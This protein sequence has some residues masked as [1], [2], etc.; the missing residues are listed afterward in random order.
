MAKKIL[1]I[2]GIVIAAAFIVIQFIPV[3]RDNPPVVNNV[4]WDSPETKAM[5]Y[6]ACADCHSNE[7]KWP[8]YSY[9]TPVSWR[10]ADHVKDGRKHFNISAADMGESHEAG[11]EVEKGYMPLSDYLIMHSEAKLTPEEKS[12]FIAGLNKT[13]PPK[14]R[15]GKKEQTGE[16]EHEK[17]EY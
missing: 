7:T 5:F 9:I 3:N 11:E 1:K 15:R 2:T 14:E 6:R 13:F 4:N 12:K 16:S 10:V 17:G 8:W